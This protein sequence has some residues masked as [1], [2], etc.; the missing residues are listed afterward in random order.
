MLPTSAVEPPGTPIGSSRAVPVANGGCFSPR[1]IQIRAVGR[2]T[3]RDCLSTT[4]NETRLRPT[5]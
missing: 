3:S 4:R 2:S 5:S 1:E